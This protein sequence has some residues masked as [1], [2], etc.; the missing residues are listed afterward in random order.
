MCAFWKNTVK[1]AS[2]IAPPPDPHIVTLTYYY[3]F[4]VG[5]GYPSFA[6]VLHVVLG[7]CLGYAAT[8]FLA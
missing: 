8:K 5:A 6:T 7:Q 4:L 1:I 3:N 2:N